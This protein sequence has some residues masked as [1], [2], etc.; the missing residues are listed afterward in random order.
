MK[1]TLVILIFL[2]IHSEL[3]TVTLSLESLPNV[4]NFLC[5]LF[6]VTIDTMDDVVKTFSFQSNVNAANISVIQYKENGENVTVSLSDNDSTSLI[7]LKSG[8][9]V[10]MIHGWRAAGNVSWIVDMAKAFQNIGVT[11]TLAVDWSPIAQENYIA[12]AADTK[13]V[14]RL[15]GNWLLN[16]TDTNN[17]K[18]IHLVGHSLGAHVS[19]FT[20]K[21]LNETGASIGRISGLDPAGP[22]FEFPIEQSESNRL[23]PTDA[24][25]VDTYHTNKGFLGFRTPCAQ[26]D[27]YVNNGGPIQP[28][29]GNI[30]VITAITCSHEYSHIFFTKTIGSDNYLGKK[31]KYLLDTW[32]T[33]NNNG[34]IIVGE[35]INDTEHGQFYVKA[36]ENA[37]PLAI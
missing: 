4:T 18:N 23:S 12:A 24:K 26:Q 32:L 27:F 14:G 2:I 1:F 20:G 29:C 34:A 36:D 28:G 16:L 33:C 5:D 21:I 37:D 10:F 8:K 11:N 22:L 30:N 17:L 15:F 6:N 25:L 31:C 9:I 13:D 19:G 35:N 3:P 7:E